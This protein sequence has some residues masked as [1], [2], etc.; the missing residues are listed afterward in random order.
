MGTKAIDARSVGSSPFLGEDGKF[1]LEDISEMFYE[2]GSYL[3][4]YNLNGKFKKSSF[5]FEASV[6]DDLELR[7]PKHSWL[8]G[9]S[10]SNMINNIQLSVPYLNNQYNYYPFSCTFII[11]KST[12]NLSVFGDTTRGLRPVF[13]LPSD[14]LITSGS[15]SLEDPYIID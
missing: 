6:I 3:E 4:E 1:Q 14:I 10:I 12:G 5:G 13:L 9:R 8:A 11:I 7:I 15:G 2:T